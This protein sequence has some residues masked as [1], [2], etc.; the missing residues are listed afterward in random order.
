MA[1]GV[2]I[3]TL[4]TSLKRLSKEDLANVMFKKCIDFDGVSGMNSG[5]FEK[6]KDMVAKHLCPN[7][8]ESNLKLIKEIECLN[9]EVIC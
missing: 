7:K 9:R 5:I 8:E 6:L 3:T 4:A 1:A 2:D